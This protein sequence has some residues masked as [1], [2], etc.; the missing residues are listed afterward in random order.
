MTWSIEVKGQAKELR[1][2]G[3]TLREIAD[4]IDVPQRTLESWGLGGIE[5]E[6]WT[7]AD[8]SPDEVGPV[9]DALAGLIELTDGRRKYL[10][11]REAALVARIWRARPSLPFEVMWSL[12]EKYIIRQDENKNKESE[13]IDFL[14]AHAERLFTGETPINEKMAILKLRARLWP[15]V[16][17]LKMAG[18]G[19][20]VR[21]PSKNTTQEDNSNDKEAS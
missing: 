13:D 11:Q 14:L 7:L 19:E 10:T 17:P 3:Y 8:A 16:A 4:K 21:K 15:D 2:R 20:V 18:A 6:S 12:V 5:D 1:R 9:L